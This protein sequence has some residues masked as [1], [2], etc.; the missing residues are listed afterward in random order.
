[1]AGGACL[2]PLPVCLG[3]AGIYELVDQLSGGS[4]PRAAS[5]AAAARAASAR[6]HPGREE[7]RRR[8]SVPPLH[9]EILT[10]RVVADRSDLHD[11]QASLA[12]VL[13]G[14]NADYEPTPAGL[15][16]T[17]A[18]GLPQVERLTPDERRRHLRR[19]G[20]RG[21]R[22]CSTPSAS[23]ATRS[24][25]SRRRTTSR[26][27]SARTCARTSTTPRSASATRSCSSCSRSAAASPGAGSTA[28][29]RSRS[30]WRRPPRF[31][32]PT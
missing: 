5:R 16:V 13:T 9:H 29:A 10:A 11:A 21:S 25:P 4:P 19:I 26:S 14:L 28:G 2:A 18:W 8:G 1:M 24:T 3:V 20:A 15:G 17:T 27:S 30:R 7:R 6:R 31:R 22:C 12:T 32:A 23:R